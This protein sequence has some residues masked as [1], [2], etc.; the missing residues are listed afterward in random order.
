MLTTRGNQSRWTN[1][2]TPIERTGKATIEGIEQV[3]RHVLKPWF[4]EGQTGVKFAIQ[5]T[6]RSHDVLTRET[7]INTVARCV[8]MNHKVD[9][10]QYDVLILVEVYK[11]SL[12]LLR[13]YQVSL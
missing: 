4:H 13:P 11:V 2:L 9:L 5:P 6:L 8:G 7:I 1:R 3:A 12:F 10:K